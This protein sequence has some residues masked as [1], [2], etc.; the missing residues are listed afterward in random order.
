MPGNI[1]ISMNFHDRRVI[2]I[3]ETVRNLGNDCKDLLPMHALTGC[4]TVSYPYGK[5][6]ITPA[7]LLLKMNLNLEQMCDDHTPIEVIDRVGTDFLACLYKG[8]P[9]NSHNNLRYRMF[10]KRNEA[11]KLNACLQLMNLQFTM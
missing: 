4:D 9:G 1:Q 10:C 6:K 5:M 3:N 8:Q 7:N 2:N 11:P